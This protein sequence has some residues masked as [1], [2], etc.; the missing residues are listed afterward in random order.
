MT[1]LIVGTGRS[2]TG[3]ISDLLTFAGVRCGHEDVYDVT[4]GAGRAAPSWGDWN[5]EASWLAVPYITSHA[6]PVVWQQR[7][8]VDVVDSLDRLGLFNLEGDDGH[9][10]FR[11]AIRAHTPHVF[12]Y[13]DSLRR[14]M[15]FVT[16]WSAMIPRTVPTYPVETVDVPLVRWLGRLAGVDLQE[17]AARNAVLA[18]RTDVNGGRPRR[19]R[20]ETEQAMALIGPQFQSSR[21]WS[22]YS[23][24]YA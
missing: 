20:H 15:A 21:L 7:H 6:G 24:H 5:A 18:T 13:P 16:E 17:P 2:G 8:P 19:S 14:A 9:G 4:V 23:D 11:A 3:Y 10:P 1:L 12:D 22:R